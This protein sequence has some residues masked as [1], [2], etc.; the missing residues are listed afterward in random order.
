[1]VEKIQELDVIDKDLV[2]V[3]KYITSW[4]GHDWYVYSLYHLVFRSFGMDGWWNAAAHSLHLVFNISIPP[5][6]KFQ[7]LVHQEPSSH[8]PPDCGMS[9]WTSN[10]A[11]V[12]GFDKKV[13]V[14]GS[15]ALYV[16]AIYYNYCLRH[17]G[18]V[19]GF[20]G[21]NVTVNDVAI[22]HVCWMFDSQGIHLQAE[23]V[24]GRCMLRTNILSAHIN[25]LHL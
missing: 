15:G 17:I 3:S 14:R 12:G 1:M 20:I 4:M 25:I 21:D 16:Y 2:A 8:I 19:G 6:G 24:H 18:Q 11:R 13:L 7:S 23:E 5:P 9:Y 22:H 10:W